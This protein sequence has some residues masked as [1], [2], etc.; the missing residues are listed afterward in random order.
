MAAELTSLIAQADD[1]PDPTASLLHVVRRLIPDARW[2]SITSASPR[3]AYRTMAASDDHARVADTA[4]FCARQGPAITAMNTRRPVIAPQ[5][6]TDE[7]WPQLR[8]LLPLLAQVAA[9]ASL[10]MVRYGAGTTALNLYSDTSTDFTPLDPLQLALFEL[11]LAGLNH[12][13]YSQNLRRAVL[14]N[15]R[16]GMA[17][18]VLM[19]TRRLTEQQALDTLTATSQRLN[20]KFND[21]A[22]E[23]CL[24]GALPD[25]PEVPPPPPT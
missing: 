20:R 9:A 23:I 3:G 17:L 10:P 7:R 21:I 24:T 1:D 22:D 18:G 8:Q 13:R 2:V 25:S 19:G 6:P 15:R 5:L 14:S 4:Q 16:I 12:H 11:A